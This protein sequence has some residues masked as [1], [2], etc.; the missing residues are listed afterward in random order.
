MAQVSIVKESKPEGSVLANRSGLNLTPSFTGSLFGLSPLSMMRKLTEDMDRIFGRS[1]Y[2]SME[3][4]QPAIEVE[5][6]PGQLKITAEVPGLNK[7]DIKVSVTNDVLTI[8]G[9]RKQEKEEKR[10][11]YYHSERSYGK[12]SRIIVLPD[13]ANTNQAT[14][15]L[16]NGTMEIIVPIPERKDERK[17]IPV[18]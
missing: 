6:Q 9:E 13:G 8:E 12:F 4:W 14:A 1:G 2:P 3:I 5:E 7:E 10:K 18:R 17:E 16:N 15:Q 11:G